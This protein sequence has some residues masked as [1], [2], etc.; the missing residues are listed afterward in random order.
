MPHLEARVG[1][2]DVQQRLA[3]RAARLL[4]SVVLG[5][6]QPFEFLTLGGVRLFVR[7]YGTARQR[8][9]VHQ[10]H[11]RAA[12]AAAPPV[13]VD[14]AVLR[15]DPL[16]DVPER[17][18]ARLVVELERG[19]VAVADALAVDLPDRD[20]SVE[21]PVQAAHAAGLPHAPGGERRAED[22]RDADH[23]D[24]PREEGGLGAVMRGTPA[25]A[26]TSSGGLSGRTQAKGSRLRRALGN[27]SAQLS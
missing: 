14:L 6:R 16:L 8:T 25:P 3:V 23:E 2:D 24:G 13:L 5:D 17:G 27:A 1:D 22:H 26:A 7:P 9:Q 4:Q 12:P 19:V 10:R 15:E 18:L 21:G 11:V 20:G